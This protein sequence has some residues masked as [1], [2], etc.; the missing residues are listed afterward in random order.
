MT[1]RDAFKVW[2]RAYFAALLWEHNGNMTHVA[3]AAGMN[4]NGLYRMLQKIGLDPRRLVTNL[5]L[6]QGPEGL[7]VKGLVKQRR[8]GNRGNAA[9][10]ELGQ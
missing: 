2:Q 5:T 9:W 4:R 7:V 1:Y 3:K 8:R 10:Q 6:E